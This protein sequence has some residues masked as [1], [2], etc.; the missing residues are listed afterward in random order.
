MEFRNEG[1][2]Y[3]TGAVA[4]GCHCTLAADERGLRGSEA[5]VLRRAPLDPGHLRESVA[6]ISSAMVT[7]V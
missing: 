4:T 6:A 1:V 2:K 3:R 7:R 5:D